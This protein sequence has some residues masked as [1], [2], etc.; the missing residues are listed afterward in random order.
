MP[1]GLPREPSEASHEVA[2]H[3]SPCRAVHADTPLAMGTCT[4]IASDVRLWVR[5]P[6][7]LR[8]QRPQIGLGER[9]NPTLG[10][11]RSAAQGGTQ[12]PHPR[13]GTAAGATGNGGG[14]GAGRGQARTRWRI[15][16]S[17]DTVNSKWTILR[18]LFG[19]HCRC[20]VVIGR[21]HPFLAQGGCARAR[22][23]G[24]AIEVVPTSHPFLAE[25]GC[26]RAR[27]TAIV[28]QRVGVAVAVGVGVGVGAKPNNA[29]Y[30]IEAATARIITAG[31]VTTRTA[32]ARRARR[33]VARRV[34]ARRVGG[35]RAVGVTD[36][37]AVRIK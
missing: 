28:P 17:S 19:R 33:V 6:R 5:V 14:T 13:R 22:A 27:A 24:R 36:N 31:T 23:G 16:H 8:P 37:R 9:G 4:K 20:R 30:T 32:T 26:A 15:L 7:R 12:A 18:F 21:V 2:S 3:G 25:G 35:V 1:K 34:G 11:P 10:R 29:A